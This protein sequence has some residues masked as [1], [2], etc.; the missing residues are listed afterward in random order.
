MCVIVAKKRGIELPS[1]KT[2]KDCFET[3]P[4]GAGLMY[5]NE[6]KKIVIEKGFMT[7]EAFYKKLTELNKKYNLKKKAL[8]MHFRITTQGGTSPGNCHP[9]PIT[10]DE[11]KLKSTYLECDNIAFAHNGII[12]LYSMRDDKGMSDTM[13]LSKELLYP[14][15]NYNKKFYK[16]EHNQE[17]IEE[18]IGTDKIAFLDNEEKII[19]IGEFKEDEG[20]LYSNLN[21]KKNYN[22]YNYNYNDYY[23]YD[24]Y[25]YNSYNNHSELLEELILQE[26][27]AFIESL[28]DEG[29]KI[30]HQEG[31][32]VY[33]ESYGEKTQ[34]Q[35]TRDEIY[36]VPLYCMKDKVLYEINYETLQVIDVLQITKIDEPKQPKRWI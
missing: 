7:F 30:L 36:D 18:I 26:D 17:L 22:Y 3:N 27:D 4:D 21:H 13:L 32:V 31:T 33:G 8:V 25:S 11:K 35:I 15:F 29:Y 9:F 34:V 12:S 20:A 6:N 24:N 5:V 23:N 28:E 19:T 2:L 1:K 14:L 16:Q 10:D